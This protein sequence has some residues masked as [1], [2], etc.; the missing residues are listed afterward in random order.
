MKKFLF[1]CLLVLV[2]PGCKTKK[3]VRTYDEN[4]T[5]TISSQPVIGEPVKK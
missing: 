5:H 3:V 4:T 2:L 1:L